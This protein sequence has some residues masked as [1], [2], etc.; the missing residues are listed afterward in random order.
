M[1]Y[2][3]SQLWGSFRIEGKYST[4]SGKMIHFRYIKIGFYEIN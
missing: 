1:I 4:R 3:I 2:T